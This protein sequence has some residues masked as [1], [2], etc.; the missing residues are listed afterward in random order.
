MAQRRALNGDFMNVR[1]FLLCNLCHKFIH[2]PIDGHFEQVHN[3]SSHFDTT[4]FLSLEAA[5]L[6]IMQNITHEAFP[7]FPPPIEGF[8][9]E[10]CSHA[11]S[12]EGS[13]KKHK[14]KCKVGGFERHWVQRLFELVAG[15]LRNWI[16]VRAPSIRQPNLR[17]QWDRAQQLLGSAEP[18]C[19]DAAEIS[20]FQR[21]AISMQEKAVSRIFLAK[22]LTGTL[23]VVTAAVEHYMFIARK[24]FLKAPYHILQLIASDKIGL[25]THGK[26]F[27][28]LQEDS[29][30]KLYADVLSTLMMFQIS[31]CKQAEIVVGFDSEDVHNNLTQL[32]TQKEEDDLSLVAVIF[33]VACAAKG[34]GDWKEPELVTPTISAMRFWFKIWAM[35]EATHEK[36]Y[37]LEIR[38]TYDRMCSGPAVQQFVCAECAT[39]AYTRIC[40]IANWMFSSFS[41]QSQKVQI[42]HDSKSIM[43]ANKVITLVHLQE[44]LRSLKLEAELKVKCLGMGDL[45][46]EIC[47][48]RHLII[49]DFRN[50]ETGSNF[51]STPFI[52]DMPSRWL[53][54]I[55][56]TPNLDMQYDACNQLSRILLVHYR[57]AS[58]GVSRSP[59]EAHLRYVDSHQFVRNVFWSNFRNCVCTC[60]VYTK[61]RFHR[62]KKTVMKYLD[63]EWSPL[64]VLFCAIVK[65]FMVLIGLQLN[66]PTSIN[67]TFMFSDEKGE[68]LSSVYVNK[69]LTQYIGLRPCD[70]RHVA[71]AFSNCHL[72]IHADETTPSH[73][74]MTEALSRQYGHSVGRHFMYAASNRCPAGVNVDAEKNFYIASRAHQRMLG[75]HISRGEKASPEFHLAAIAPNQLETV[76]GIITCSMRNDQQLHSAVPYMEMRRLVRAFA[77]VL[78]LVPILFI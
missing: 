59:E 9:C 56:E 8:A 51:R 10:G 73:E 25:I 47:Q 62:K 32:I 17:G 74:R 40:G 23:A 46:Q 28:A 36:F 41:V 67:S 14:Q 22:C 27:K 61:T 35:L 55:G 42:S 12:T 65:P 66:I 78:L 19:R 20:M 2:P 58:G 60:F 11:T 34:D 5:Q 49:D 71:I 38:H 3:F 26:V 13:M 6:F 48:K 43:I 1:G 68:G 45:L 52:F 29:T 18:S 72:E 33:I 76:R 15:G 37:S 39:A 57:M 69:A 77:L 53:S 70:W 30:W 64:Y 75:M 4:G 63:E 50:R 16:R 21:W 31:Y 24:T 7:M 54:A 44:K